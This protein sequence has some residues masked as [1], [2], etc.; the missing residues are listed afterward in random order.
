MYIDW[1]AKRTVGSQ[2][3]LARRL[4]ISERTLYRKLRKVRTAA[5]E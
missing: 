2:R 3:A 1:A 4:G 5:P